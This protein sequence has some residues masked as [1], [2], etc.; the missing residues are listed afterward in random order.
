M[1]VV[2]IQYGS[3]LLT[4]TVS[5]LFTIVSTAKS[6]LTSLKGFDFEEFPQIASPTILLTSPDALSVC[7]S[8]LTIGD[9]EKSH[10]EVCAMS[11][12]N[13]E[14]L[15]KTLKAYQSMVLKRKVGRE[16][17]DLYFRS[18]FS[19]CK[20]QILEKLSLLR[21]KWPRRE[22]ELRYSIVDPIMEM[23]C[24]LWDLKV[25]C[26]SNNSAFYSCSFF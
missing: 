18:R 25:R 16:E 9:D 20:T 26:M 23:L 10:F 13:W 7:A 3:V 12:R 19:K 22:M 8:N 6:Y 5:S 11:R 15:L 1:R 4:P 2:Q 14:M 24:E 17:S 21:Y